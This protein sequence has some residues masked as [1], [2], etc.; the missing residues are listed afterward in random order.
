MRS[1]PIGNQVCKITIQMSLQSGPEQH[2][3]ASLERLDRTIRRREVTSDSLWIRILT[4][5]ALFQPR[6]LLLL[7][8]K[9]SK[10]K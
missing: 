1:L 6:L 9:S 2:K 10:V 4:L 8:V 7:S 3:S 5:F